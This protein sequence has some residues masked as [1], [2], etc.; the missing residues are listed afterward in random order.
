MS[1]VRAIRPAPTRVAVEVR[2]GVVV[3]AV[4][5]M[6]AHSPPAG[7]SALV[8]VAATTPVAAAVV[9]PAAA[10]TSAVVVGR[11]GGRWGWRR[12][13]GACRRSA[14]PAR[15]AGGP[16]APRRRRLARRELVA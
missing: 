1:P 10:A 3:R 4:V 5:A 11:D 7:A 15:G 6:G 16:C 14:L 8:V 9:V 12:G 2:A 13:L